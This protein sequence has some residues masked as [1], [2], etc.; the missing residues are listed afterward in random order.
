MKTYSMFDSLDG[1]GVE[2]KQAGKVLLSRG[3]I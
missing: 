3:M 2:H 1:G